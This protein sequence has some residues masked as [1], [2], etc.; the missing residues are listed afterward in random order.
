MDVKVLHMLSSVQAIVLKNIESRAAERPKQC[1]AAVLRFP[2][3]LR[4]PAEDQGPG[5]SQRDL[6]E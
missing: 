6:P 4:Q 5:H 2:R 1:A 3:A